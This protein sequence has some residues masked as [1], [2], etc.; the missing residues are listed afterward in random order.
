LS[1]GGIKGERRVTT[2][3]QVTGAAIA[4]DDIGAGLPVLLLHGFPSTRNLWC[5][6][7]PLLVEAGFRTLVPDLVGGG[8]A[9]GFEHCRRN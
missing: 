2:T 6:V 3:I 8:A 7:V 4:V 9:S 5:R 1:E